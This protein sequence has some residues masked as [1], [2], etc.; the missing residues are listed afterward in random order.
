[1]HNTVVMH[2][3]VLAI[4]K[5]VHQREHNFLSMQGGPFSTVFRH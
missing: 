3:I 1:M 4:E 5:L 2:G